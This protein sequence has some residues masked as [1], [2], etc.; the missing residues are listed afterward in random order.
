[1]VVVGSGAWVSCCRLLFLLVG[2]LVVVWTGE[3]DS[4]VQPDVVGPSLELAMIRGR[5]GPVGGWQEQ[6][7]VGP[8][9]RQG[10]S[11]SRSQRAAAHCAGPAGRNNWV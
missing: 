8:R 9:G 3:V 4:K 6:A 1:M 5:P 2:G 10:S 11:R 7:P